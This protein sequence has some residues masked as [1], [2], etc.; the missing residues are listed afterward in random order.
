MGRTGLE[1][2]AILHHRLYAQGIYSAGKSLGCALSSGDDRHSQVIFG[3]CLVYVQHV[4]CSK[5]GLF[6]CGMG[7]MPFLPQKLTGSQKEPCPHL[8]SNHI[9][10]LVDQNGKISVAGYPF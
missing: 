3:K 5:Y 8:P 6:L 4:L 1:R 7:G 10:P 9:R 2:L